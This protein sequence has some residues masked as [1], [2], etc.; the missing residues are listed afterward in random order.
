MTELLH[1]RR[2]IDI[3]ATCIPLIIMTLAILIV[4]LAIVALPEARQRAALKVI[5]R[6]NTVVL[7]LN[8]RSVGPHRQSI[9]G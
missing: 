6:L 5:D 8:G 3:A 1:Q 7:A 9:T 2:L 4:S